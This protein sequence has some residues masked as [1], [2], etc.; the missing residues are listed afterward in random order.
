LPAAGP[1][2]LR[3]DSADEVQAVLGG[4]PE[5]D[6]QSAPYGQAV[7]TVCRPPV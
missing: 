6:M 2:R 4:L 3:T 5:P 1:V 7:D